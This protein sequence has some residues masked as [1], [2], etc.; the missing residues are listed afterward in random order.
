[1][2]LQSASNQNSPLAEFSKLLLGRLT[3]ILMRLCG[4]CRFR[5]FV[6]REFPKLLRAVL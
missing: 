4:V 3:R 1:M 2:H 6:L 5:F